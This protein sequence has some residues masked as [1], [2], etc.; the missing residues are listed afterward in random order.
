M[1]SP[2]PHTLYLLWIIFTSSGHPTLGS[3]RAWL[4]AGGQPRS[5]SGN[6]I[7]QECELGLITIRHSPDGTLSFSAPEPLRSGPVDEETLERVCAASNLQREM[8]KAHQHVDNGPGWFAL[9]L[10]SAKDVLEFEFG[11]SSRITDLRF[12]LVGPHSNPADGSPQ[13]ELR[14]FFPLTGNMDEDPVTG[15]LNAGVARWLIEEG[16]APQRYL[17]GQGARRNRDGR[18]S[19]EAVDGTVWVGGKTVPCIKGSVLL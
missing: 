13:F 19:V 6:T 12:G 16:R 11:D 1:R 4:D 9:L 5:G 7:I 14:A 18:V 8:I 2:P 3:C 17:A 10:P 15:S